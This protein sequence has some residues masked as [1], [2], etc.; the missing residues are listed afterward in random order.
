M[1]SGE[2]YCQI[3]KCQNVVW[4]KTGTG[5]R[6]GRFFLLGASSRKIHLHIRST[7]SALVL[8]RSNKFFSFV[9]LVR[10]NKFFSFVGS[11]NVCIY[12]TG[13]FV[14]NTGMLLRMRMMST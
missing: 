13:I 5:Y 9:V 3:L 12:T 4:K 8:D 7:T 6:I 10:S 11:L 2:Y 1:G 14:L